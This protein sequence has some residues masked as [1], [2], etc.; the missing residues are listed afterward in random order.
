MA[1]KATN[2]TK[3]EVID[4]TKET[5]KQEKKTEKNI[6]VKETNKKDTKKK[7]NKKNERKTPKENYF[8]G[9][10]SELSKVKWPSKKEVFKY[11]MATIIFV[12]VLV[13]F[14]LLMSAIMAGI[15]EV[16]N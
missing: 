2:E 11:T 4:E 14:F 1:K 13:A 7:A 10:K 3:K 9:V 12:L 16:F 5:K 15:K 6:K 8:A